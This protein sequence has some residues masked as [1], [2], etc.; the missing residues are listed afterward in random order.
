TLKASD[1]DGLSST[2]SATINAISGSEESLINY[3]SWGTVAN[4]P[5]NIY[6]SQG[7]AVNG[8]LYTFG[9]FDSQKS[10]CTPT[11]R[12]YVF[13]PIANTWSPIASMPAMNGT[14]YGG[15]THAGFAT[16]GVDIYF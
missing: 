11:H 12:A 2:S 9:G 5:Y 13:D 6:E 4:Q 8:K 10:C 3:I 15:V 1:A 7:K 14:S 16:D